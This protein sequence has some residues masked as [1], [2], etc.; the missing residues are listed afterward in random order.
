[1]GIFTVKESKESEWMNAATRRTDTVE[2][3]R[4]LRELLCGMG[5]AGFCFE[6]AFR[7]R[8]AGEARQ[9]A[10]GQK[11]PSEVELTI[12]SEWWFGTKEE[13]R[14]KLNRLASPEAVQPEEPVQAYCLAL[15][16]WSEGSGVASVALTDEILQI[17]TEGGATITMSCAVEGGDFA[18][19]LAEA[20]VPEHE[21]LWSVSCASDGALYVRNP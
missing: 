3:E 8:F 18:W 21:A 9:T 20:G 4:V 15:L 13:W 17:T 10:V 14:A 6:S 19:R 12:E 5:F 7:L 11:V 1:L 2:A 16:R